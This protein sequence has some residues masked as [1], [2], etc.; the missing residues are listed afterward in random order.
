MMKISETD[1]GRAEIYTPYSPE[2]VNR[3]RMIGGAKWDSA[4]KCWTIPAEAVDNCRD[5]MRDVYGE[6]DIPDTEPRLKLRV[7]FLRDDDALRGP[8]VAFGKTIADARGRDSGARPGDGVVFVE[9]APRS[10]GSAKNW[11][12]IVPEGCVV[13]LRNVPRAMYERDRDREIYGGKVFEVAVLDD[14]SGSDK[15]PDEELE[16]LLVKRDEIDR[17][18]AEIRK[19]KGEQGG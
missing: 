6:A 16:A 9:G 10:G 18:I 3:I 11:L 13:E 5:I 14:G 4:K 17:R 8:Y 12:S 1:N 7:K 15:K 2:F 19:Q